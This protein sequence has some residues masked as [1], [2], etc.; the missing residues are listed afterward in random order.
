LTVFDWIAFKSFVVDGKLNG[1]TENMASDDACHILIG[2]IRPIP[3]RLEDEASIWLAY[4]ISDRDEGEGH[5][6]S[7]CTPA[8][9]Q[10]DL[11]APPAFPGGDLC[12]TSGAQDDQ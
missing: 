12:R 8:R 10:H 11:G 7:I 6:L 5:R 1:V 2:V 9:P 4:G 3:C